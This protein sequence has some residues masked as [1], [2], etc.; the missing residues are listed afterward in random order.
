MFVSFSQNCKEQGAK[1]E[2]GSF[3]GARQVMLASKG[4][5]V[6]SIQSHV[7]FGYVGNK[8]ATFPMQ[9]HGV[10]V[11]PIHTVNFA[12]HSGYPVV[13]G[14]RTT[15]DQ[16]DALLDGLRSNNLLSRVT[17]VLSGYIGTAEVL[18]GVAAFVAAERH[19]RRHQGTG[20][21]ADIVFL[22]DPVCG[23][24]GKLYVTQ[25]VLDGYRQA[26]ATADIATPNG[27]EAQ[28]LSGMS[29]RSAE[30]AQKAT[31]WFLDSFPLLDVI[32]IKSFADVGADPNNEFIFLLAASRSLSQQVHVCIP[33]IDGYFTG[34]GDLFA[35]MFLVNWTA[36]RNLEKAV[37]R[38]CCCLHD[39]IAFTK[40]K[41]SKE[42]LV[43]DGRQ[44]L[45][46][47]YDLADRSCL[48]PVSWRVEALAPLT[49]LRIAER[50]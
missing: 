14:S 43:V 36:E 26:L 4:V 47:S 35:A 40:M 31:R 23:D 16:L 32:V 15:A 45:E 19:A 22:C 13:K 5:V 17:H 2:Q 42:L 18:A 38:A 20:G 21:C 6:L 25:A 30:E 8:A 7:T 50:D 24:E 28:V 29:V 48:L 37:V 27:F 12:N 3:F 9:L 39:V 33:R 1:G 34:T 49:G 41:G 44:H 46:R 10:D 11:C